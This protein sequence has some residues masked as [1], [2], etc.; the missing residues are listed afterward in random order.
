[1]RILLIA[2]LLAGFGSVAVADS[3]SIYDI[4][5]F[6]SNGTPVP[7]MT[8]SFTYDSTIPSFSDFTVTWDGA[9]FDLT[10]AANNPGNGNTNGSFEGCPIINN[11]LTAA[12]SFELLSGGCGGSWFASGQE[13]L[14]FEGPGTVSPNIEFGTVIH[15]FPDPVNEAGYFKTTEVPEPS[16]LIPVALFCVF[17][18]TRKTRTI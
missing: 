18:V 13:Q 2:G 15:G 14:T 9:L 5:F 11:K 12:S 17:A 3:I 10:D 8:G 7:D 1:M 6:T 4:S 16:A